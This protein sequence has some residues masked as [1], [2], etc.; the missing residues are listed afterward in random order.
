MVGATLVILG[1]FLGVLLWYIKHV[2]FTLRGSIPGLAPQFLLGNL[3]QTG[4]L[5]G[6]VAFNQIFLDLHAKFGDVFQYWLGA[7]RIVVVSRLED[8]QHIY[9][10]RQIYEQGDLFTEKISLINPNAIL[11]M[12]GTPKTVCLV[13]EKSNGLT[14]GWAF[15]RHSSIVSPLFRRSKVSTYLDVINECTE[16]LITRWHQSPGGEKEIHLNMIEQCQQLLMAI[17]GYVAFDYDLQT[18]DQQDQKRRNELTEAFGV[19]LGAGMT[20]I[21][22]PVVLGRLY[23]LNPTYRRAKAIIDRY[24]QQM[25]EQELRETPEVRKERKRTSLIA[26]LVDSLQADEQIEQMKSEESKKGK[27]LSLPFGKPTLI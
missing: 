26:S 2:Y 11:C 15:K 4:V 1:G 3:L 8:V 25:I 13:S 21:R 5:S 16:K 9:S 23:L 7:T 6:G 14:L 24:L 10:H 20:V 12:K 17:F 19:H 22:L 27:S 18:L